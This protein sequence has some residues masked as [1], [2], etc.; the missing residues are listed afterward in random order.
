MAWYPVF[1]RPQRGSLEATEAVVFAKGYVPRVRTSAP[2]DR[3]LL[4]TDAFRRL[5]ALESR[6]QQ[7]VLWTSVSELLHVFWQP[8][9]TSWC[10]M[11]MV[12]MTYEAEVPVSGCSVE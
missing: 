12:L 9:T 11:L 6:C 1:G 10:G 3:V 8:Q 2:P 5:D 7:W 4:G